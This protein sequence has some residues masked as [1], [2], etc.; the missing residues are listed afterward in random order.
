MWAI[1][2]S[3]IILPFSSCTGWQAVSFEYL[4]GRFL[5]RFKYGSFWSKIGDFRAKWGLFRA[6]WKD[7]FLCLPTLLFLLL[8]MLSVHERE[9]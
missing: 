6:K 9:M 4:H 8:V 1:W 3:L 2:H 7:I 5:Q